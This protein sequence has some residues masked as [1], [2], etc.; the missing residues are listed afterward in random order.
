MHPQLN[1]DANSGKME[2]KTLEVIR[3]P[4]WTRMELRNTN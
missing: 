2:Q 4:T 1:L 3:N